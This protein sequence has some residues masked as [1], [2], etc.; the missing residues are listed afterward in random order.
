MALKVEGLGRNNYGF[1]LDK[2]TQEGKD[3][4]LTELTDINGI[5]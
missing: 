2:N 3:F 4:Q 1:T 5:P